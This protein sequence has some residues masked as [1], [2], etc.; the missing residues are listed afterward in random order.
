MSARPLPDTIA[1]D[2]TPEALGTRQGASR[3]KPSKWRAG[4]T[5]DALGKHPGTPSLPGVPDSNVGAPDAGSQLGQDKAEALSW[6]E[7]IRLEPRLEA[8]RQ[9]VATD[10]DGSWPAYFARKRQLQEL[11]GWFAVKRDLPMGMYTTRAFDTAF[12]VVMRGR[13]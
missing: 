5:W 9:T 10:S 8:L 6:S 11:V 12:D 13:W 2:D 4:R 1:Q 7:L 3:G